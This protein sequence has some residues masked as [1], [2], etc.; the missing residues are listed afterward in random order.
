LKG[1]KNNANGAP[2]KPNINEPHIGQ[3]AP[4]IPD[5]RPIKPVVFDFRLVFAP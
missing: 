1:I 3:P 4:N 2:K 5:M